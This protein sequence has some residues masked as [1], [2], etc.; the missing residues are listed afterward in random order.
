MLELNLALD[1]SADGRAIAC[2]TIAGWMPRGPRTRACRHERTLARSRR[3]ASSGS[4]SDEATRQR[5]RLRIFF[6]ASAGVGK[7]Y[8]MLAA[9]ARGPKAAAPTSSS[10]S[11]RRTAAPRPR[12]CCKASR[13]CRAARPTRRA[14]PQLAEFDLDAALARKPALI[15]VDELAHSNVAGLAPSEALAGR[16]RAARRG[17]RRLHDAQRPAP[18]KPERRRRRHHRLRVRETVPDTFFDRADEVVLVDMPADELLARLKAGKVYARPQAERAAAN[19]F[20]KGNLMALRELALR[21]TADRVEDDVQAYR[22]DRSIDASGRP[23]R[24]LLCCI[25]PRDGAEH[26]VRSAALL[27]QQLA[28]SWHAVYVETPA[29]QRLPEGAPRAHPARPSSWPRSSARRPRCCRAAAWRRRSSSYAREHNLSQARH[30]P[31][32]GQPLA[33]GRHAGAAARQARRRRRPDRDRRAGARAADVPSRRPTRRCR[34]RRAPAGAG[35]LRRR[36]AGLRAS[37]RRSSCRSRRVL[38]LA[39]IV[40]LYL[41]A[42]VGVALRSGAG[43]RC[44]PPSSTCWR[45]TSSSCRRAVVRASP[46]SSTCSPSRSCWWS[47][48]S[49]ASSPPGCATR[50]ASP[51]IASGART[52]CSRWRASCR[53]CSRPSRWSRPRA[54]RSR[55]SSARRVRIY[56]LDDDDGC[57]LAG[58]RTRRARPRRRHRALGVRPSP[59]RRPRHRHAA[60]QRLALP[61]AEGA[62]ANARRARPAARRARACSLVPEQRRQLETFAA[63]TAIALERVHY[64]EV[65]QNA[66]G[67]DRIGAAAQLAAVGAVARPAHA[68]RGPVGLAESLTLTPPGAEPAQQARSPRSCD[69]SAMRMNAQVNNLLDMARLESGAVRLRATGTRSRRWWAARF[70]LS[71]RVAGAA[72]GEDRLPADLPLVECDAVLIERVLVNLLENAAKYT[73]ADATVEVVAR[74]AGDEVRVTVS[75]DGPG[76][77]AGQRAGDLRE[78]HARRAGIGDQRRRPRAGDLQGDRRGARRHDQRRQPRRAAAPRSPSRCRSARHSPLRPTADEAGAPSE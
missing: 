12:R 20:R 28:V 65:A 38:D 48:W 39:N 27:A 36:A 6:G 57:M 74:K 43:R 67:A 25:G 24:A 60:R 37:A 21:R 77:R 54:G 52:R 3:A 1:R 46:T 19:F 45:S 30:G 10:A 69:A 7:T 13:C 72:H 73:P 70:A 31:Q 41:L 56:V 42:V 55:A 64:V 61:A 50:R 75:D 49:S 62:D 9:R 40:M 2:D 58:R 8:A 17:H 63:L 22:V 51:R 16:R 18:R 14:T 68:A 44:S 35:R 5:G 76:I 15:L 23:R 47:A 59:G 66:H 32:P 29:L 78:V 33:A 26:V 34:S 53:A 4:G 11:S 71:Q